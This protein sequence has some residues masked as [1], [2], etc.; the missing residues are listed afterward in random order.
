M[1][2]AVYFF[3]S[4]IFVMVMYSSCD[5]AILTDEEPETAIAVNLNA[6][7]KPVSTYA[8]N[9]QWETTDVIGLFMKRAGQT[10]SSF[11]AI[12]SDAYNLQMSVVGQTLTSNPPLMYPTNGNVDFI[13]YYPHTYLAINGLVPFVNIA[14]QQAGLPV[15]ILYSNNITNQAPTELPVTLNFKY[16]LAKIELTL[17]GGTNSTLDVN[18]F[19]TT[20]VTVEDLFTQA[21]FEL[22]NGTFFDYQEKKPIKMHRKSAN[23]TSATFEALVFPTNEEITFL[24]DVNGTIYQHKMLVSYASET[25]YRYTFALDFPDFD[26]VK[27]TLLSA[28]II[29]RIEQQNAISIDASKQMT[30]TTADTNVALVMRGIGKIAIDWGDGSP[31][32]TYSLT[33][34][35]Y[36]AYSYSGT[37]SHTIKVIGEYVTFL[38]YI[39]SQL[40]NLDVSKN[41]ALTSLYCNSQQLTHLDVSKNIALQ[42]L[43]CFENQ[44]TSLDVSKNMALTSLGCFQN[45]LACL[46]VSNNRALTYLN[47]AKNQLLSLDVSKNMA[48]IDL[49][50]SNNQLSNLDV[51]KNIALTYLNCSINGLTL[52]D[53][54]NNTALIGFWCSDNQISSLDVSNNSVLTAFTCSNNQLVQ[55]DVSD[56]PALKMFFCDNNQMTALV[57]GDNT[58]LEQL[59]CINNQLTN[60]DVSNNTSLYLLN[61]FDNQ[62]SATELNLLFG[63]LHSHSIPMKTIIISENP[64]TDTCDPRIAEIKG[65]MVH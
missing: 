32:E 26:Q 41:S 12:Y 7:I 16:A 37:S 19:S 62:F 56:N 9:D 33:G 47:C 46:D 14:G 34:S 6:G 38:Q 65:W 11:G 24:F 43:W 44:L 8:V 36:Y 51:S 61:C 63:T 57:M 54:K 29:P 45:Q 27:T 48:L 18:D 31:S 49:N 60:L 58:V 55:L 28:I 39:G 35:N 50:C 59:T 52:L 13:A 10:L 15:E 42:E 64:G 25:L 53:V 1:K 30:M 23:A 22:D 40:T 3:F 4:T 21:T 20:T 5:K 17:T 2:K